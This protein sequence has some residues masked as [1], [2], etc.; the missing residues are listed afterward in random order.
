M[1][2]EYENTEDMPIFDLDAKWGAGY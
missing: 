1:K 2:S